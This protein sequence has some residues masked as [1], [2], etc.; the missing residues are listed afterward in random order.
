M[1]YLTTTAPPQIDIKQE[2]LICSESSLYFVHHYCQIAD[3]V[4]KAWIPFELWPAQ[5]RT[6]KTVQDNRHTVILKARQLGVTWL[7]LGYALWQ[8][9]FQP[10]AT[11]LLFSRRDDEAIE[12]LDFR[13]KGMYD[14][15]P[16]WMQ[17]RAVEIDS[18]HEFGLSNGSRAKA[19]PTTAGDSYNATLAIADEFDL[20]RNQSELMGAVKPTID[21]GGQMILLSRP[22]KARPRTYFKNL[23]RGARKGEND[24]APVFLPW[25]AHPDRNQ[26]WYA[27]QRKT[28]LTASGSLD[29]L[30][31]QYPET[32]AQALAPSYAAL[33]FPTFTADNVTAD[34]DYDPANGAVYWGADDGYARGQGPG[35]ADYHP[36]VILL[37]QVTPRGELNVF[38]EYAQCLVPDY[39]ITIQDVLDYGYPEPEMIYADSSASM[40]RAAFS[41][42]GLYNV[43]ATHD[44]S[45]GIKNVRRLIVDGNDMRLLRIHPRCEHLIRELEGYKY[46]PNTTQS[47]TG[48]QKPL[49]IDDHGPDALRYLCWGRL[50]S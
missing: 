26:G 9:L 3:S 21:N 36:R 42:H 16:V 6:L 20:V 17:A 44:V 50:R 41:Q 49:K 5:A 48:E 23:Y 46:N 37:A 31:E 45:E 10:V 4:S 7:A 30:Y 43:G 34:A 13:L 24:W 12:L 1:A 47:K 14:R 11:V 35:Y 19:F 27:E 22:D 33:V 18:K 38:A 15:L 29:D 25:Y 8:M 2:W 32:E 28:A 40:F 39:D